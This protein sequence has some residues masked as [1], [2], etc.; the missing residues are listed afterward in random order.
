VF[1]LAEAP[2]AGALPLGF[3][4]V[5][6]EEMGSAVSEFLEKGMILLG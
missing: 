5:T 4:L 1:L 3:L 6:E 2:L